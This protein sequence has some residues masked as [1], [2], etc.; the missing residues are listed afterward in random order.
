MKESHSLKIK[1][2]G[3]NKNIQNFDNQKWSLIKDEVMYKACFAKFSQNKDL[4]SRLL[5]T[6][7]KTLVE[8]S[9]FDLYWGAGMS[10]NDINILD[11]ST[12]K[13][14]NKL[15]FTLM[16]VRDLIKNGI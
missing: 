13:G 11:S 5:S 15:G 9:P 16:R 10:L 3:A 6:K 14:S 8:A 7:D 12:H 1:R 2:L 4:K